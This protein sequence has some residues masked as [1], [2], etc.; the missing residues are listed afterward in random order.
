MGPILPIHSMGERI[1]SRIAPRQRM[2]ARVAMLSVIAAAGCARTPEAQAERPGLREQAVRFANGAVTLA[3]TLVVPEGSGKHP[4]VVLFHGS[5]PQERDLVMARWFAGR[6]IVALAYDKRG[7]GEST[8]NFKK[9][10]F[11]ELCGD[12]LAGLEHLK[13]RVEVD[14]KRIG[15]WGLSQGGWLGPLAASR[16]EDVAWVIAVSG[17][18]VSPGEQMIFYYAQELRAEGLDERDVQE[19]SALRRKVWTYGET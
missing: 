7:V 17:P 13:S 18:G 14:A 6:G 8:G 16:S 12:G 10:P 1:S 15:V 2:C 4:A 19:V 9:V 5:G 3:G 11:M